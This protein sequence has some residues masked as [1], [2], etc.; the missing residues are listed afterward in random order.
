MRAATVT[1]LALGAFAGGARAATQAPTALASLAASMAPGTFAELTSNGFNAALLQDGTASDYI[2][3]YTDEA[4]WDS[5]TRQLIFSGQ[6]HRGIGKIIAYKESTNQWTTLP[7]P[8]DFVHSTSRWGFVHAYDHQAG[9]PAAGL[10]FRARY[11][12]REIYRYDAVAAT[13]AKLT[14]FQFYT[15]ASD[16]ITRGFEYFPEMGA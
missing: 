9:D 3:Q 14:D 11:F 1:L 6:S 16:Q 10:Y 4:V 5:R 2:T 7:T 13:W 15:G 8:P 12:N